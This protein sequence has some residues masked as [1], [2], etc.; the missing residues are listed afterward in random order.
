MNGTNATFTLAATPNPAASLALY[1]NGL[2]QNAGADYTLSGQT[3]QFVTAAVP[4]PGIRC[5]PSTV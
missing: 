4:Q 3:V 5:W 1:R 2:L